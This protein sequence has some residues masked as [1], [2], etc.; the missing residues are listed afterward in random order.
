ML[1]HRLCSATPAPH[2]VGQRSDDAVDL[3]REALLLS[4]ASNELEG[5]ALPDRAA[6]GTSSRSSAEKHPS[7]A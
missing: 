2:L 6:P 4:V 7:C 3:L 5:K 1:P